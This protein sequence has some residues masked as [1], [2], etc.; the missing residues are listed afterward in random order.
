MSNFYHDSS[1]SPAAEAVLEE[2]AVGTAPAKTIT[3]EAPVAVHGQT[4]SYALFYY[5]LLAYIFLF[6][7]RLPELLPSL[8]LAMAMSVI[9]LAGLLASGRGG[10]LFKTK[11]GKILTA[12]TVWVAICVPMSVW[13]GGSFDVLKGVIQ[14]V[15]FIACI[16]AFSRTMKEMKHCM[17]ALG[18]SMGTVAV[19]SLTM[20]GNA[21]SEAT[22]G[23][24]AFGVQA[25][26]KP[27]EAEQRL[28]LFHSAT[29]QDPNFMS[30]YLLIGLPFLWLGIR[31]GGPVVR[32]VFFL[33]VPAVFV[34]IGHSGSRMAL[35]LFT[36]LLVM[37]LKSAPTRERALVLM[38]TIVFACVMIPFLPQTVTNRFMT[39]FKQQSDTWESKEAADSAAVRLKL[40]GR[41]LQITALHPLFGVGPGQFAV[42]ENLLAKEE[43]KEQ[44]IWY[45]THNAYTQTSSEAGILALIL[46]IWA[47]VVSCRGL[48]DIRKR[49]PTEEI[50]DMAKAM[51]LSAWMMILGGIFLT[52][53]F[54]G[55]PF[56]IMGLAVSFKLAVADQTRKLAARALDAP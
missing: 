14:S 15:L 11:I 33:F 34:A 4:Q 49:G 46:Y 26:P 24:E 25:P 3:H 2:P 28:G 1:Y 19:L 29:L 48:G 8:H 35:I 23:L 56:L 41:S 36:V 51:Q 53:G 43:G 44:G 10:E 27:G 40:L 30:L 42:A 17:Y 32:A 37:F 5:A 50:R 20:F 45:Y 52:T 13:P 16:I 55:V 38:G 31:R 47:I 12:F 7:T 54:G 22:T 9:M 21:A 39:L 18:A 6:C